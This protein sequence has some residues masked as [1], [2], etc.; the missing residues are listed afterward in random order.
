ME[1][2]QKY[3]E[4]NRSRVRA[5]DSSAKQLR[6]IRVVHEVLRGLEICEPA[7]LLQRCIYVSRGGRYK[8]SEREERKN[9]TKREREKRVSVA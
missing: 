2:Q 5:G 6:R 1:R 9:G 8:K 7:E 3:G 4:G